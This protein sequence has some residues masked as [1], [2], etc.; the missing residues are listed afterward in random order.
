MGSTV[1]HPP[2]KQDGKK[3]GILQ[4]PHQ[5]LG[6]EG[7]YLSA[8][9]IYIAPVLTGVRVFRDTPV[10]SR[11]PVAIIFLEKKALLPIHFGCCTCRWL[12][13]AHALPALTGICTVTPRSSGD[14]LDFGMNLPEIAIHITR[15]RLRCQGDP[16]R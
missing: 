8:G 13:S 10:P 7:K 4:S 12:L 15:D 11:W 2:N 1:A 16:A 6:G 9:R 5:H 3:Q 14:K